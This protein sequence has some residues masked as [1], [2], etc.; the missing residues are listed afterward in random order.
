MRGKFARWGL[1]AAVSV[2]MVATAAHAADA[3]DAKAAKANCKEYK[4]GCDQWSGLFDAHEFH[5][6]QKF[7]EA[8]A[9]YQVCLDE[10][11]IQPNGVEEATFFHLMSLGGDPDAEDH[12]GEGSAWLATVWHRVDGDVKKAGA[13]GY[14]NGANF[15]MITQKWDDA[16]SKYNTAAA[17]MPAQM[18]QYASDQYAQGI[19]DADLAK[20]KWQAALDY[21]DQFMP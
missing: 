1:L 10:Q 9:W 21:L 15:D 19:D 18:F 6:V 17:P 3:E 12:G 2:C 7:E 8:M 14:W 4:D 13:M 16:V 5:A 20:A 11:Y